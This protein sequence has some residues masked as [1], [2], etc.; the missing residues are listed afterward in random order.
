MRLLSDLDLS[1][2]IANPMVQLLETVAWL[3]DNV[4]DLRLF[5][6]SLRPDLDPMKSSRSAELPV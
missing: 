1:L 4:P 2:D 3:N 6:E 5:I